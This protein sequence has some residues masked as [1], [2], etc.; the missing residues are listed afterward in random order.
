V[1]AVI[2]IGGANPALEKGLTDPPRA[3][4][5]VLAINEMQPLEEGFLNVH[6]G[7]LRTGSEMPTPGNKKAGTAYP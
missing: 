7:S 5:P 3:T 2:G 6:R 4:V 1:F